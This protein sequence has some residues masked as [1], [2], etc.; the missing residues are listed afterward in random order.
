MSSDLISERS[1]SVGRVVVDKSFHT[2]SGDEAF[3]TFFGNDVT[4]SI[5]RTIDDEDFPRLVECIE[6]T[7]AGEVR[8]TVIRMKGV[9][10]EYRW[11]LAAVRFFGAGESEPLYSITFSDVLSLESLAYS[12]ESKA[13]EYRSVLSLISDLAFEYS[14]ETKRIR[15][16]MFDCFREI[17]LM[18]EELEKW[19][20]NA[21]EAGYV[22]TR[23]IETFNA[24]CRDITSGVYR[25]DHELETSMFT[26]GKTRETC[27]FRGMTRYD[28]PD[29]K[30]VS[31]IISVVNSRSRTKDVNLALE[32]NKDS[33]SGL[34]N[35]RAVTAFTQEI[36]AE[37]PAY[38]VNLVILDIDNFTDINGGYGH[39]FGDEVIYKVAS[40]IRSAI[41]SRGIAGRISGSGFLI[42]LENTRDEEDLR[43]ILRAIRTNTEFAFADRSDKIHLTCSMGVAT[44]PV[45]S[46]SYDELFMQADKALYI[47]KEKGQN[48]YVIYD[49]DKHGPVEKDMENKI[50]FLSGKGEASKKLSFVSGLAENLVLGRIPDISVLIEQVRSQFGIDD[51]CVFSGGDMGLML[52]CG[53]AASKNASYLLENNY[54]DRFSGDGIFVIDNVNELEGRDDNAFAKLTEQN[55]G[56]AVQYL[57]TEDSMIKGMISFCYIGRFKKWSV[58]DINYFAVIGR[59]ISALL[60]KQ[61]YI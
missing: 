4:Y 55:I 41:G 52:S 42:V 27:L 48:R 50:A 8:R 32:A 14:F 26:E 54:T 18:D 56:G 13:C 44:Y 22:L 5:R 53:N 25:F 46:E 45:D 15:I 61:A 19:R 21:V 36:L 10:G 9:S 37:K 2:Q 43:G 29:V 39:L 40:V 6:N 47:A 24:L 57:I 1:Y 16:Y 58:A 23:Y 12:R 28:M 17:V 33:L 34:L 51:I 49:V 3:F 59:A 35:K 38:N 7:A 30:R 20:R 31:G 60:K 11:I